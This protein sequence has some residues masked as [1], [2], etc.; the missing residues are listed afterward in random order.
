M[1][2]DFSY[3]R[4]SKLVVVVLSREKMAVSGKVIAAVALIAIIGI[5]AGVGVALSGDDTTAAEKE[6]KIIP[7]E[8]FD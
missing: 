6:R 7:E 4:G 8:R 3:S 1:V 5:G 2:L